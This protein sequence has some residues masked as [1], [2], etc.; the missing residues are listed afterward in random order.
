MSHAELRTMASVTVDDPAIH[1][2]NM[3][4]DDRGRVYV[5]TELAGERVTVTIE[6]ENNE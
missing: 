1:K 6:V 3:K 2:K 4:V 5:G